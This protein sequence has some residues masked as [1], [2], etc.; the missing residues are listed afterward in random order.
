[1]KNLEEIGDYI[2]AQ[3]LELA[4]KNLQHLMKIEAE[5]VSLQTIVS[6]LSRMINDAR[7]GETDDFGSMLANQ[8][9]MLDA[10]FLY[11]LDLA[12]KSP[13]SHDDKINMALKA[14]RQVERTIRTWRL[15]SEQKKILR[16][17]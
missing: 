4:A 14:Q 17:K 7:N 3:K 5:Q 9:N 15:V 1:M 11:F 6:G 16:T 13:N 8:S 12:S 2:A 10:T